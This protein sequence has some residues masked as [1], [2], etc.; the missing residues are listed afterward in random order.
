MLLIH[1]ACAERVAIFQAG[2]YPQAKILKMAITAASDKSNYDSY[3][4]MRA[5]RQ[6]KKYETKAR[7]PYSYILWEN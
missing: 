4:S 7:Y 1:L 3:T 6:S 5:C 2:I